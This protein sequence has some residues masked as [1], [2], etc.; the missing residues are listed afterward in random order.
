[1]ADITDRRRLL[2]PDHRAQEVL[3]WVATNQSVE[4]MPAFSSKHQ[5]DY[6]QLLLGN[7]D[8]V[9]DEV[10]Y[11]SMLNSIPYA[12][13]TLRAML[14]CKTPL[15]V[16]T[17]ATEVEEST[18]LAYE[19]LFFDAGVFRNR[20]I[21]MAYVRALN[22]KNEDEEQTKSLFLW[23]LQLGWE[24][25][26]WKTTGGQ[27][28]ISTVE[29]MRK[30]MADSLWRSREHIFNSITDKRSKEARAWMP[31]AIKLAEQVTKADPDKVNSL[32]ELKIRLEGLDTTSTRT[33]LGE[34]E[35]L[36]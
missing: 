7:N 17:S 19:N 5:S 25:L 32:E 29:I 27:T 13:N 11:A 8:V 3:D 23:G 28:S 15:S 16:I 35:I 20:L 24:Y 4:D 9:P 2:A 30:L 22:P 36:S 34:V 31:L 10:Y 26:V 1:M 18:V 33:K 6:A 21:K 14:F 12:R